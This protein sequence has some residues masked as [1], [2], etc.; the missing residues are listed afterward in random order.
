[1]APIDYSNE[2]ED[3]EELMN[4]KIMRTNFANVAIKEPTELWKLVTDWPDV[5]ETRF[6]FWIS[7]RK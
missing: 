3:K 1:M 7:Q 2:E 6:T 5:F 4:K